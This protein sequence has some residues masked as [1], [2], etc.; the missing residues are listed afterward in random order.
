MF[1]L[2]PSILRI[3][4]YIQ[5]YNIE[6]NVI[7]GMGAHDIELILSRQVA[8]SLSIAIFIVDPGGNLLYYNEPAEELLG[9]KFEDTGE[10]AVAEW[11]TIWKPLDD[12]GNVFPPEKLPLV[13]TLSSH[14]P[15]HG[16][17]WIEGLDGVKRKLSVTSYPIISRSKQFLAAV[18]MFWTP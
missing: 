11:S 17:F 13:K 4:I 14:T 16:S 8:E 7:K 6:I 5:C 9:K 1:G 12:Q 10:M 18:A 3:I 15:H 2:I